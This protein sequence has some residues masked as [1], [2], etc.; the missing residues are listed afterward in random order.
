ML[1]FRARLARASD[2]NKRIRR[3]AEGP[4]SGRELGMPSTYMMT[5]SLA[6]P[7]FA[8]QHRR[9]AHINAPLDNSI[10]GACATPWKLRRR[11]SAL[12]LL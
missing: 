1:S 6:K 2:T 12:R 9:N 8:T 5:R 7:Y 10:I 4:S 3:F 11:R